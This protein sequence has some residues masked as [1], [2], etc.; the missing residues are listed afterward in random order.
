MIEKVKLEELC[1]PKSSNL[2][3]KDILE[4][5]G[6]YPVYGASGFIKNVDFY[7]QDKEYIAVVKDGAGIG[8]TTYL[9]SKSSIIGTMQYLIPKSN[10]YP[11]YLYYAV[12]AMNLG[13]YYSGATIPHIYFK[14]YKKE[15]VP[16]YSDYKQKVISFSLEKLEHI[17]SLKQQQLTEYDQ[18]IKSR[19]VEMFGDVLVNDRSWL[20]HKWNDVLCIKNGKNQKK[21]E[22]KNG[23]YPICGSGGIMSYADDYICNENSVIIG[24]KGNINNP[25]LMREKYWNVDTA[26]GLEPHISRI[27][28][29]YLY[30]FCTFYDF[31]KH[32]K[33]VTIPSL[34]KTDLLKIDMPIPPIRMQT[35]FSEFVHQVDKLKFEECFMHN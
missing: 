20:I 33:T 9:P 30:M 29:D 34:T 24:R 16:L 28:V 10:V 21:V 18:L 11:K 27:N 22:N 17:I 13:K 12:K 26:F 7:H 5:Y 6:E 1:I 19:F 23:K 2:A 15:L 32:N 35:E 25:I 8:R 31:L 14:D 4:N 3:Q